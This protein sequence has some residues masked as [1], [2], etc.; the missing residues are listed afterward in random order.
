MSAGLGVRCYRAACPVDAWLMDVWELVPGAG[1]PCPFT[2][3]WDDV[4]GYVDD[5]RSRFWEFARWCEGLVEDHQL[6]YATQAGHLLTA[7]C[8]AHRGPV[9][10]FA[11]DH[12]G[13]DLLLHLPDPDSDVAGVIGF[14]GF[15]AELRADE[16]RVRHRWYIDGPEASPALLSA[17]ERAG[18]SVGTT[19]DM[20]DEGSRLHRC[21]AASWPVRASQVASSIGVGTFDPGR[22]YLGLQPL[23]Q[24]PPR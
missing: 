8:R 16:V 14:E 23:W 13:L 15:D 9:W 21:V 11:G 6:A 4:T 12:R 1:R 7:L 5:E 3:T 2:E 22:K 24:F 17:A 10:V 20:D 18:W 19:I